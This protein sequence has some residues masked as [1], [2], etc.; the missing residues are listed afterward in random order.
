MKCPLYLKYRLLQI[1]KQVNILICYQIIQQRISRAQLQSIQ[2]RINIHQC[3]YLSV[4]YPELTYDFLDYKGLQQPLFSGFAI[5]STQSLFHRLRLAWFHICGSPW[6]LL[7]CPGISNMLSLIWVVG[8]HQLPL[9]SCNTPKTQLL[10]CSLIL[11]CS[12]QPEVETW[13]PLGHSFMCW[14]HRN[15]SMKILSHL[16]WPQINHS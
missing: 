7:H 15:I 10:Y 12:C 5:C 2:S 1:P 8:R 16:C 3:K 13:P 11:Y 6:L 4:W 14:P 9:L